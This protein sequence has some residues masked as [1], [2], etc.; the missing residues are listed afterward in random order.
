LYCKAAQGRETENTGTAAVFLSGA[1]LCRIQC[2]SALSYGLPCVETEQ[3]TATPSLSTLTLDRR[4]CSPAKVWGSSGAIASSSMAGAPRSVPLYPA[5]KVR[6][7]SKGKANR[8]AKNSKAHRASGVALCTTAEGKPKRLYSREFGF[9]KLPLPL[10]S[11]RVK[12]QT[13]A[14]KP[15]DGNPFMSAT[16]GHKMAVLT[17]RKRI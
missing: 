16:T 11:S 13:A 14:A 17:A 1:A 5:A 9:K 6:T 7:R 15:N 8:V 12:A 10:H 3:F 4:C 2:C